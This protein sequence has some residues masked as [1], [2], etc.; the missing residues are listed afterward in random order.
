MEA[1]HKLIIRLL[2]Y[3]IVG[4]CLMN[5]AFFDQ[6]CMLGDEADLQST[7]ATAEAVS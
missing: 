3:E 2:H 7:V 4:G 6:G 5:V 1:V